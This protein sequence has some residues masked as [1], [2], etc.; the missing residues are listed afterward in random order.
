MEKEI[1]DLLNTI[2][3]TEHEF[4]VR[5]LCANPDRIKDQFLA[6]PRGIHYLGQG[7]KNDQTNLSKDDYENFRG[8]GEYL[9]RFEDDNMNLAYMP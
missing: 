2:R 5:K 6:R 3:D 9:L 1:E 7:C 8:K 4:N